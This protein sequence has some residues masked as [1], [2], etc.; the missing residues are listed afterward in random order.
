MGNTRHVDKHI[1]RIIGG[2][3]MTRTK[4]ERFMR[5]MKLIFVKESKISY[6]KNESKKIISKT[7][8][9]EQKFQFSIDCEYDFLLRTKAQ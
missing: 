8:Q 4:K 3:K 6:C 1:Q 9:Y 7:I 2:K 5:K